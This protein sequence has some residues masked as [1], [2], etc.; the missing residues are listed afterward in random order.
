MLSPH[1]VW[2]SEQYKTKYQTLINFLKFQIEKKET[3][4]S[5]ETLKNLLE[6]LESS[7]IGGESNE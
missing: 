1:S 4:I 6:S 2:E 7:N 3:F 5:V